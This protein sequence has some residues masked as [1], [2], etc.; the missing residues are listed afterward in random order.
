MEAEPQVPATAATLSHASMPEIARDIGRNGPF[1]LWLIG[2]AIAYVMFSA[3]LFRL[4][5]QPAWSIRHAI[6]FTVM[7]TFAGAVEMTQAPATNTGG[8]LIA[9]NA[10]F[11][12]T[13]F[14]CF[15]ALLT[16]TFQTSE[17][18]VQNVSMRITQLSI[19]WPR[20]FAPLVRTAFAAPHQQDQG[21]S[22]TG[23]AAPGPEE[24]L[25]ER[26]HRNLNRAKQ[27]I[28]EAEDK[29]TTD[30]GVANAAIQLREALVNLLKA[31][32]V[33]ND[34]RAALVEAESNGWLELSQ[35]MFHIGLAHDIPGMPRATF[36]ERKGV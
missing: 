25:G 16:M 30:P 34:A 18:A 15:I 28:A 26:L 35:A 3:L 17:S 10:L 4:T 5:E 27:M 23:D 29:G 22:S 9:V 36:R 14:G 2:T 19:R 31:K 12:L 1:M 24:E 7:N 20:L 32:K 21:S 8:V 13:L 6:Y 11:G 33:V